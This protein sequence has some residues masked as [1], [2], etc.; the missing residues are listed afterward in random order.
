MRDSQSLRIFVIED[1][2][3]SGRALRRLLT[4]QG[5]TVLMAED[6]AS[7]RRIA[8]ESDGFDI[9][10]G[11]IALPDGDGCELMCELTRSLAPSNAAAAMRLRSGMYR[12]SMKSCT[13]AIST[14]V[15]LPPSVKRISA[16]KTGLRSNPA[17]TNSA[18][19]IINSS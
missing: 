14:P 15:P 5:H 3:D 4:S 18:C 10:I 16:S 9:V 17:S 7:A 6:C 19:A 1:H 12:I 13:N 2:A 11:D 8:A